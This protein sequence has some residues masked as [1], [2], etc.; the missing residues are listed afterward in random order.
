MWHIG[1]GGGES[2]ELCGG[3]WKSKFLEHH[4]IRQV[5]L[6]SELGTVYHDIT[7]GSRDLWEAQEG[8]MDFWGTFVGPCASGLLWCC[9]CPE[10][11]WKDLCL[12][13]LGGLSIAPLNGRHPSWTDLEYH[14]V[15][16]PHCTNGEAAVTHGQCPH[17]PAT[18]RDSVSDRCLFFLKKLAQ[19]S[20][21]A[22]LEVPLAQYF[23]LFFSP[24]F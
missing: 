19:D 14:L 22:R 15:L 23:S 2:R 11:P 4:I 8:P 12:P 5:G 7:L 20:I 21:M 9:S 17:R 1:R 3:R 10:S 18:C 16:T 13:W 6:S 24:F